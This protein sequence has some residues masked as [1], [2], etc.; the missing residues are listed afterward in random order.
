M[1]LWLKCTDCRKPYGKDMHS[2][3]PGRPAIPTSHHD[4]T[5][6]AG[7]LPALKLSGMEVG[8]LDLH[9]LC[10]F[11]HLLDYFSQLSHRGRCV[12]IRSQLT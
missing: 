4:R 9:L 5:E 7:L 2:L 11:V 3:S 10:S 8:L 12:T 1:F 6:V